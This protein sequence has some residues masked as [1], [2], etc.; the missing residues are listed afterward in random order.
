MRQFN[1]E[2][3]YNTLKARLNNNGNILENLLKKSAER[4]AISAVQR[5]DDIP[6][7]SDSEATL[8]DTGSL[9][10]SPSPAPPCRPPCRLARG[11]GRGEPPSG[12]LTRPSH[13]RRPLGR[14]HPWP[15]HQGARGTM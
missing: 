4:Q 5:N 10:V 7:H 1:T 2:G 8:S 13:G 3:Y 9:D 12:K 14:R 15:P 6:I 11:R